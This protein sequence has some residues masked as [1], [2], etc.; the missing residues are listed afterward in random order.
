[1]LAKCIELSDQVDVMLYAKHPLS[2]S[3]HPNKNETFT[4]VTVNLGRALRAAWGLAAA[5]VVGNM[6]KILSRNHQHFMMEPSFQS[7]K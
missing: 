7:A 6:K 1:M 5:A 2:S 4:L 3:N